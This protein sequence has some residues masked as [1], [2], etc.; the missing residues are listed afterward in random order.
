MIRATKQ[1]LQRAEG[2]L[3]DFDPHAILAQFPGADVG[4]KHAKADDGL[5]RRSRIY[6]HTSALAREGSSV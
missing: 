1:E 2:K 5:R 4:V 6:G 3:L